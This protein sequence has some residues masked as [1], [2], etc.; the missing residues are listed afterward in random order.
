MSAAEIDDF[1]LDLL[2]AQQASLRQF[3]IKSRRAQPQ[4]RKAARADDVIF[5]VLDDVLDRSVD[6]LRALADDLRAD[7]IRKGEMDVFFIGHPPD[8]EIG[9]SAVFQQFGTDPH[10]FT[11]FVY[12]TESEG[13]LYRPAVFNSTR[14][15][16]YKLGF[17]LFAKANKMAH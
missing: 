4:A 5:R 13:G 1:E 8:G 12:P 7:L 17:V 15:P 9:N 11:R 6:D 2:R 10:C 16:T 14:A 3:V